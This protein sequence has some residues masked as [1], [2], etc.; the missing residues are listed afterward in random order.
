MWPYGSGALA[1]T[2]LSC[3]PTTHGGIPS[4]LWAFAAAFPKRC[5][6]PSS[7]MRLLRSGV[8]TASPRLRT[9]AKSFASFHGTNT[10]ADRRRLGGDNIKDHLC[11]HLPHLLRATRRRD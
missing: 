6:M 8:A 1:S 5:L 2:I 11:P 9:R 4:R 7:D 10:V 3:H